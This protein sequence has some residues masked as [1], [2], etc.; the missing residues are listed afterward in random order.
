MKKLLSE[1]IQAVASPASRQAKPTQ[2]WED[3]RSQSRMV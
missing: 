3:R 2:P 1:A